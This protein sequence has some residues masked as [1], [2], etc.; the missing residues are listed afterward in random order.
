M[1]SLKPERRE[2]LAFTIL[3]L[4]TVIVVIGILMIMVFSVTAALR[5]KAER[6]RCVNNLQGL[7]AAGASYLTDHESWPQ[8]PVTDTE[9][10]NFAR[11]WMAA[12]R[13]YHIAEVN[14]ICGAVQ[15]ALST[16]MTNPDDP[17]IDYLPT[18]F[19]SRPNSPW[20]FPTHPWFIERANMHGD[21]NLIIFTNGQI[22]AMNELQSKK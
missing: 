1:K 10:P 2:R 18:S 19:D 14:W 11:A 20:R 21:G 3:E 5:N 13:P 16:A 17:R 6:G 15:K 4:M 7:Y 9:D 12:F 22:R 8:I